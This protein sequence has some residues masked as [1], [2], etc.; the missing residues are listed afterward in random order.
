LERSG[1][2]GVLPEEV[3]ADET[4]FAALETA[5]CFD[6]WRAMRGDQELTPEQSKAVMMRTA[7]ALLDS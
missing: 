7:A 5:L 4:L 3:R 2:M 1:L 6:A